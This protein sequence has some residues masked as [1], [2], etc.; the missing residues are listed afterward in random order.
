MIEPVDVSLIVPAFNEVSRIQQTI[1]ESIDYL[2]GRGYSYEVIVAADGG[3]GT[4]ELV[5]EMAKADPGISVIGRAERSGKGRGVREAIA[6]ARGSIV[7]YLDADNKVP[8]QEFEKIAERLNDGYE[9][10]IGSRAMPESNVEKSQP[11]YRRL[12]SRGFR[13]VLSAVVGLREISDTQCGFKFFSNRAAKL[14]F[15]H[16]KIDGYM[17]DVEILVLAKRLGIQ[18]AQVPIRWRDDGDSRLELI[19]GNVRN[20]GDLFRIRF[21]PASLSTAQPAPSKTAARGAH[22]K[23]TGA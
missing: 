4:R 3:D 9:F 10:V 16:Q 6:L 18:I 8:I 13:I 1:G 7:G 17:F 22:S 21:S 19:A 20:I 15:N 12:G 14:I 11:L 5:R 23:S 2:R